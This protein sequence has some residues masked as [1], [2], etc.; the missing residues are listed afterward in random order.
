MPGIFYP[1]H[2]G[3]KIA[4]PPPPWAD[5]SGRVSPEQKG[6]TRQRWSDALVGVV[7]YFMSSSHKGELNISAE[8]W[9]RK[10]LFCATRPAMPCAMN[11]P[12]TTIW[13]PVVAHSISTDHKIPEPERAGPISYR[14]TSGWRLWKYPVKGLISLGAWLGVFFCALSPW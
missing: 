13:W 10:S 9:L 2:T 8:T 11:S 14:G 12:K 5:F 1:Y 6:K 7:A 3:D 4:P